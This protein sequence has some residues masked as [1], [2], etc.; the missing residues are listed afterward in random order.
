MSEKQQLHIDIF[1]MVLTGILIAWTGI[2]YHQSFIRIFPLFVSLIISILQ[3][4]VCRYA[5][6]VGGVNS[7][8]YA[9]SAWYYGLY[10]NCIYD[11]AVSFPF[12]VWA[13]IRWSK[14][15]YKSSTQLRYMTSK[16]RWL[17]L[18]AFISVSAVTYFIL[19]LCGSKYQLGDTLTTYFGLLISI[20]TILAYVE[21]TWLMI[22]NVIAMIAMNI[23]VTIN[24]HDYITYLI[25][26][27]FCL[28]CMVKGF[29]N[30]RKLYA[31]QCCNKTAK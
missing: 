19:G 24:N 4:R 14:H 28:Y 15:S 31:E 3:A 7:L 1:L 22:P 26:S 29:K 10:A 25:F 16:Q 21:Y 13:F 6:I 23:A 17:T 11:I 9:Y 30:A 18:F 12:Q 20:L 2:I 8:L 27:I 5:H